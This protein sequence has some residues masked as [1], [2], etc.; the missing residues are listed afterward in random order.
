MVFLLLNLIAFVTHIILALGDRLYQQ[1]RGQE[2]RRELWNQLRTFM[3]KLLFASW[4]QMLEFWLAD[5]VP[6]P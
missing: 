1:C 6:G 3:N 4:Q 2:S 5:E